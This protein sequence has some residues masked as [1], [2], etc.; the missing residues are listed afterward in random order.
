MSGIEKVNYQ[1]KGHGGWS[2]RILDGPHDFEKNGEFY[3]VSEVELVFTGINIKCLGDNLRAHVRVVAGS[4]EGR[5]SMEQLK[6]YFFGVEMPYIADTLRHIHSTMGDSKG[7]KFGME[8]HNDMW[9]ANITITMTK[10]DFPTEPEA[11]IKIGEVH[12]IFNCS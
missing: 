10:E 8:C 1:P 12:M 2:A 4:Q 7:V 3:N 6:D 9:D 11:P 5:A